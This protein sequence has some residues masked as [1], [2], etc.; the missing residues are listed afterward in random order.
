MPSNAASIPIA[1]VFALTLGTPVAAG[2]GA[3]ATQSEEVDSITDALSQGSASVNLRYRYEMVD[4]ENFEKNAHAST[5]RTVL[6]YRT[7]PFK[8]FSLF[9]EAQNVT[10]VGKQRFNNR[11]AGDL[12]NGVT[13]RPVVADP[14][15]TRVQHAYLRY[16]ALDTTFDLGRRQV[17]FGDHRFVGDVGWRQNVQ[18]FDAI[19]LANASIDRTRISYAFAGKVV[20]IF[21]D[22]K[23][24]SSHFVNALV[25]LNPN[26]SLELFAYLLDYDAVEDR[27]LSSQSYGGK[28]SGSRPVN[29]GLRVLYEAQYAKQT[30]FGDNPN[31]RNA[32]YLHLMGGLGLSDLVNVRAARELLSGSRADGAFQTPLATGH[33]FNGW[34]D[35]FLVTPTEGLVDWYVS[36]DGKIDSLSWSVAYHDFSADEGGR[37]Y[38]REFDA[39]VLH[40]TPWN[41]PFGAKVAFYRE[42]GFARD[43]SKLWLWT[44]YSF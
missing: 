36:A 40:P 39:Q 18:T 34:A 19:H 35:L 33:K 20:R 8:G 17:V 15:Q 12:A 41:M 16:G 6:G 22:E 30:D 37:T 42:D 26:T 13:D 44:Q 25:S 7:A 14:S 38:G 27:G 23:D 43:V 4:D 32:T 21:G 28:L 5:L 11:G 3:G 10:H 29:E 24:M 1:F 9:L 31:T 2:Q